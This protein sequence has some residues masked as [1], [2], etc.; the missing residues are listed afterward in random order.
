MFPPR[1]PVGAKVD[2]KNKENK[3]KTKSRKNQDFIGNTRLD[4]IEG[5]FKRTEIISGDVASAKQLRKDIRYREGK[6]IGL[7]FS[8]KKL[9]I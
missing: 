8:G 5:F 3:R 1:P 9:R 6:S 4:K 7:G 2:I